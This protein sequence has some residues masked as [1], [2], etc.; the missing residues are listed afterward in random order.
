LEQWT[1]TTQATCHRVISVA[2]RPPHFDLRM[3]VDGTFIGTSVQ[4]PK[5]SVP[6]NASLLQ[7]RVLHSLRH[8][9]SV[10]EL[11]AQDE[12]S[13]PAATAHSLSYSQLPLDSGSEED[14]G[15]LCSPGVPCLLQPAQRAFLIRSVD[16]DW[17]ILRGAVLVC[18]CT[19]CRL[20]ED[21]EQSRHCFAHCAL[22]R[23]TACSWSHHSP[24]TCL[25][26]RQA[27]SA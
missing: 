22:A 13:I 18:D 7:V 4:S 25:S 14:N 8:C 19:C 1:A 5:A 10:I 27:S 9:C 23:C 3:L 6:T 24:G 2:T 15:L 16:E 17:A 21:L 20:F 12:H 11:F 26:M